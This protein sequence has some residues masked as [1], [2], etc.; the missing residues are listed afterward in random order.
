MR[1]WIDADAAPKSVRQLVIQASTRYRVETVLV[2]NFPLRFPRGCPYLRQIVVPPKADAA[3]KEII[4][5]SRKGDLAIT[6]DVMLAYRLM[7]QEVSVIDPRG[8]HFGKDWFRRRIRVLQERI[9]RRDFTYQ[10]DLSPADLLRVRGRYGET[11]KITFTQSLE[12]AL[13]RCLGTA[14]ERL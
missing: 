10:G 1:I 12:S 13:A 5:L 14:F 6:S 3:D 7:C 8:T 11:H 9:E 2:S 4:K